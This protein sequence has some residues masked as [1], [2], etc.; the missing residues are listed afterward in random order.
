[1]IPIR[2]TLHNFMPYRDAQTLDF[3]GI[4]TASICGDNGS[5]KSAIIDAITWALWGETRAKRD[6][7]L[8]HQGETE[9]EV[10][11]E[12]AVGEQQYRVLRRYAR[13][14]RQGASGQPLL[15][16]YIGG[17][18]G[19][20]TIDGDTKTQTQHK[21]LETLHMDYDTFVNSAYLRQGHADAFTT[22]TPARRKE[23][24]GSILG[25]AVYE[26]LAER[27]RA[28]ARQRDT[29]REHLARSL[30]EVDTELAQVPA[31]EAEKV[32]AEADIER[33]A[34]DIRVQEATL[35]GLRKQ[36]EEL[37]VKRAHLA[38]I[39]RGVAEKTRTLAQA[40][41]QA[42]QLLERIQEHEGV[43]ARSEEIEAGYAR[44][45]AARDQNDA[46]GKKSLM[47]TRLT[48]KRHD[49]EFAI[50]R[51]NQ[52]LVREQ[53]QGQGTVT[54]LQ[55]EVATLPRLRED[56]VKSMRLLEQFAGE[57]EGLKQRRQTI[58]QLMAQVHA[59]DQERGRLENEIEGIVE[60][61][62]LLRTQKGAT[63]PLCGCALGEDGLQHIESEFANER[64]T[65]SDAMK[66]AQAE[67]QVKQTELKTLVEE[68]QVAER[69]LSQ[70]RAQAQARAGALERETERAEQAVAQLADVKA[71]VREI[72]ERLTARAFA[73]AEQEQL[74]QVDAAFT[75]LDYDAQVHD[76]V[77]QEYESYRQYE[78]PWQ[79][80]GEAER[81]IARER[82]DMARAQAMAEELRAGLEADAGKKQSLTAETEALPSVAINLSQTESQL[83]SLAGQR[84][85][86]QERLG[87]IKGKLVHLQ[88]LAIKRK[89]REA[90]QRLAA[91]EAQVYD[92]LGKAFSKNGVQG[93][94]IETAVPEIEN[95]ANRLLARMTDNR[96]NVK[97][98]MQRPTQKGD[99]IETLDIKI[100][101]ELGT[102]NYELFSGGEAF[103]IDF[104]IR[105][106]L[107]RL[108]ARRAGAP[109]PTLIID[110]G[111]GTQ[112]QAGIEKLREAITS[113]QDDFEK[114]LV[115]TH[116][117]ELR[118]AFPA[119]IEVTKEE[120][121]SRIS[122]G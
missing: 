117:E 110:E 107:S 106:A 55:T 29:E 66:A 91:E 78:A 79:Q 99:A 112:D 65:R 58:Q 96:M 49:L 53:A 6:D 86:T 24:L 90:D 31:C 76:R 72:E 56:L 54:A 8:V 67:A 88:E 77:R 2:L 119:R 23:V 41:S 73:T 100:S 101:D 3:S 36:R 9:M 46:L 57:E 39:E 14:K 17:E 35:T 42:R 38:L 34:A 12:F 113:I 122:L 62:R 120:N 105:I 114:V 69:R 20:R 60:K 109:L 93:L 83:G 70:A 45:V 18:G 13:P 1:M 82:E 5:G 27:A 50:A 32:A 97:F 92:D 10:D 95:E 104:S 74:R 43:L 103:R 15:H 26:A 22:A 111:F 40:E 98:E 75:V 11:F 52:A 44:F 89:E 4:H 51:A 16:L 68:T 71:Q 115:I 28:L 118:D 85:V 30:A 63:C 25:L 102:R 33:L 121:G 47:A 61:L 80:L 59:L 19:F 7:D 87:S 48:Q 21:I 37:E 81:L 64:L 94:I 108:L 84:N 116:I